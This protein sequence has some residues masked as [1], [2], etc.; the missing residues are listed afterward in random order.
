M[1]LMLTPSS[2][3]IVNIEGVTND[4][5]PDFDARVALAPTPEQVHTAARV[6]GRVSWGK[7]GTPA[8]LTRWGGYLST[9]IK[10]PSATAAARAFHGDQDLDPGNNAECRTGIRQSEVH[11][12]EIEVFKSKATL[13]GTLVSGI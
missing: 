5:L 2:F 9:R 3:G 12:A 7:Y 6:P 1:A 8:E 13:D 10:A 11:T 4:Q